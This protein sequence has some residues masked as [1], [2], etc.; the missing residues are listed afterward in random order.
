MIEQSGGVD[1]ALAALRGI[2]ETGFARLDGQIA[3]VIQ[4]LDHVDA[5]HA[6]LVRRVE[7]DSAAT[8]AGTKAVEERLDALERTTVTRDEFAERNRRQIMNISVLFAGVSALITLICDQQ[9]PAAR[10]VHIHDQHRDHSAIGVDLWHEPGSAPPQEVV[11]RTRVHFDHVPGQRG[12]PDP[13]SAGLA[14]LADL[15]AVALRVG[16]PQPALR[17]DNRAEAEV[18]RPHDSAT[19]RPSTT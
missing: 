6:D 5:R 16:E 14:V 9:V 7:E 8:A 3:L 1:V 17:T 15:D 13:D 11:P 12:L 2:V 19:P 4:R 18:V 10:T